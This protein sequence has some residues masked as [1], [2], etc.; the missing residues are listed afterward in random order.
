[1]DPVIEMLQ[2]GYLIATVGNKEMC[3]ASISTGTLLKK[4]KGTCWY[5]D[6]YWTL[7]LKE[8]PGCAKLIA[9]KVNCFL[10]INPNSL[11]I[12]TEQ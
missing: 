2:F 1:M 5:H 4:I 8:V 10:N 11:S 6:L 7:S 9:S 12:V 3:V